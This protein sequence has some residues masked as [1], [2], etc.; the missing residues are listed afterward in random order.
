[1]ASELQKQV[2]ALQRQRLP[3]DSLASGKA[4]LFLTKKEAGN[5][6]TS[7]VFEAALSGLKVLAQYD[8]RFTW[9]FDSLLHPSSV[10]F[11]RELKTKEVNMLVWST[12][13]VV[14]SSHQ[15]LSVC[16]DNRKIKQ[17]I[18]RLVDY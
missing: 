8:D 5:V 17:S 1:M 4:S 15:L 9:C 7:A 13:S 3:P 18:K 6:D 16:D 12:S 11:Q 10:E 2:A 14:S